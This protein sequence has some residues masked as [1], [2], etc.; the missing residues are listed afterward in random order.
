[1][2]ALCRFARYERTLRKHK[3]ALAGRRKAEEAAAAGREPAAAAS[4]GGQ[5]QAASEGGQGQGVG[6]LQ[7]EARQEAPPAQAGGDALQETG[8]KD[9]L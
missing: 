5:G 6:N 4:E 7:E 3:Q 1:M 9:E 8:P 2:C